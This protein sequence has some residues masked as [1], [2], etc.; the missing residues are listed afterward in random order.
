[1]IEVTVFVIDKNGKTIDSKH[2]SVGKGYIV[3]IQ[4]S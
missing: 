1:M 2:F 4:I 3:E